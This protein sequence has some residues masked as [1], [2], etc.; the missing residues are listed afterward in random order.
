MRV[1]VFHNRYVFRGGEDAVVDL[2][3]ELLRKAGHE[4]H[5]FSVDSAE[6]RSFRDRLRVGLAARWNAAMAKRVAAFLEQHPVQL[7]H[8]HNFF[9]LLSPAV[10]TAFKQRG[11][12]VVQTLHNYRFYCANGLFLR[13]ARPCEDCVVRGPW[14]AMRHGCYR[15]SRLQTLAWARATAYQRRPRF[16]HELV[17]RFVTPSEFARR[18]LVAAGLPSELVVVKPNPVADPGE[19][20][21]GGH[22]AV[23]VGRLSAEKGVRLLL[24]AW[25]R[26]GD[27]PL[28]IVGTG[29]EQAALRSLAAELPEVRL[30]GQLPPE[31]VRE[32][33]ARA[34]FVVAPSLCYENF[35]LTVVEAMAA[36]KPVIAPR[37]TALAEMLDDGRSGWLFALGDAGELAE[38]CRRLVAEPARARQMGREARSD[39][40]DRFAPERSLERLVR[41]YDE[42][43]ESA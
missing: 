26:L 10:H 31:G 30:L 22:G 3:V 17:D 39:Y 15:G 9:P 6:I 40:E 24:E 2:E 34:A 5:L 38:A 43:L 23:Y 14:N 20:R 11:L 42:V 28:R 12:A 8:V 25:R 16:W 19:P 13:E 4:V 41:L 35:P 32:E 36:G 33:L 7:G 27:Y 18:K 21:P 1:A 37:A 29:P